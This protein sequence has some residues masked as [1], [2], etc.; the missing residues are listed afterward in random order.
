MRKYFTLTI[1][2][3]FCL[4]MVTA[5]KSTVEGYVFETDNRGFLR[6]VSITVYSINNAIKAETMSNAE[7]F[8]TF[9]VS[10]GEDYKIKGTKSIFKET[11]ATVKADELK[12][13][14][15]AYVNMEMPRKPGYLFDVTLADAFFDEEGIKNAVDS[16]TIE[17]YNNTTNE[18]VLVLEK[19]PFP[20]FTYT[21]EQGNHYTVM[22]RK[23]EYFT[24]RME[25]HVNIDGCILCFEGMGN[26]RPSDNLT[27]GNTMGSLLANVELN[28]IRLSESIK[29][30]NIYYDYN[31]A[32]I[33]EDAAI[34]LDKIVVMM[35]DNP[36][37]I[38]ELG[39]HTDSRGQD[40]YNLE[41][42]ERRAK[43]A[44]A[45][46]MR[47]GDIPTTRIS[48]RGYGESNIA[49]KCANGIACS[50]QEHEQN[51]RTMI[52]V[53]GFTE[54]NPL[55]GKS[56]RDIIYDENMEK[57]TY[58]D[59]ESFEYVEGGELPD[60]IRKDLERQKKRA[61]EKTKAAQTAENDTAVAEK[62]IPPTQPKVITKP[63][64]KI[65]E[66]PEPVVAEVKKAKA[67]S[68]N[69]GNTVVNKS[70]KTSK[71]NANKREEAIASTSVEI[72]PKKNQLKKH[73]TIK[74][75][76]EDK[77]AMA[78][79]FDKKG[80]EV[81][82]KKGLF[83]EDV[84]KEPT[85]KTPIEKAT[86]KPVLKAKQI[87]PNFSGY[88]IEFFNSSIEL[89]ENHSIFKQY[90]KVKMEKTSTGEYA[91][92]ISGF[93]TKKEAESFLEKGISVRFAAAKV[94]QFAS[95]KRMEKK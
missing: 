73:K 45:Y 64:A 82:K 46:I 37:L 23:N 61:E 90:G 34:E 54:D 7:G 47:K 66:R 49:N 39:S 83:G 89:S 35:K 74:K 60:E 24:K 75:D 21:F 77:I 30:E 88:M 63:A 10:P 80:K 53:V 42:S 87:T 55:D 84:M 72:R 71:N 44:V 3:I 13:G 57:A 56:L 18:E 17:I 48:A 38:I 91:Y 78:D 33:R 69:V 8:F 25:A 58:D 26:V 36:N 50:D 1:L 43:S 19:H 81:E 85:D 11:F 76:K 79:E 62:V 94:V 27:E 12:S 28:K 65:V 22:V 86:V 51:R 6:E 52:K 67:N 92:L 41:L 59:F 4:G 29:I 15:I 2:A 31:K 68:K 16:T 95:G 40:Q 70:K 9:E 14:G 93:E 5:Q 20:G 32:N